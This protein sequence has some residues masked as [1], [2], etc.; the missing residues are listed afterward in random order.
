MPK[1]IEVKLS[2]EQAVELEQV[3]NQH[4]KAYMRERAAAVLKVVGGQSLTEVAESALLKR[5]EPETIHTW[6]KAYQKWGL[7]GWAIKKGRGRKPA[8]SPKNS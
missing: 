2:P 6:I 1:R 5:H 7:K 4:D 3:R 8:F